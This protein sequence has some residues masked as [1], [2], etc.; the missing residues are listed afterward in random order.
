MAARKTL[1]Q[2]RDER[3]I[4]TEH[5]G[6]RVRLKAFKNGH[7][8]HWLELETPGFLSIFPGL[9]SRPRA[10]AIAKQIAWALEA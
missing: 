10:V 7:E 1:Q 2:M 4:D 8:D 3:L 5:F 9:E 6:E